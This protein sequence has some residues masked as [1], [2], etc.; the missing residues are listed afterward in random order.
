MNRLFGKL[1]I[2]GAIVVTILMTPPANAQTDCAFLWA[3]DD[4]WVGLYNVE[5]GPQFIRH[6]G[7]QRTNPWEAQGI[8]TIFQM[9]GE[10]VVTHSL[11]LLDTDLTPVDIDEAAWEW[12]SRTSMYATLEQAE[13]VAGCENNEMPRW[14]GFAQGGGV[15]VHV[16]LVAVS[17]K[18]IMG[19]LYVRQS[20]LTMDR[21]I[22]LTRDE[23]PPAN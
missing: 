9:G 10:L 15:P 13:T 23:T 8:A 14:R 21:Q 12:D 22:T 5:A 20:N 3:D 2:A 7:G 16:D 19:R 1:A 17:E 18:T 6:A 11:G 4:F